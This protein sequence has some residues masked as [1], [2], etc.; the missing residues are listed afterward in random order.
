MAVVLADD[1]LTVQLPESGVVVG[2]GRDEVSRVGAEGAVPDPPLVTRQ[3]GLEGEGLGLLVMGR[4]EI[5]HLPDARGVVGAAG[6]ELLHVWRQEDTS[7]ILL[8]RVE[9][10]HGQELRAV[11]S[12]EE[13]PDKDV[14]LVYCQ[15]PGTS[16]HHYEV[17]LTPLLAAQRREPSLATVTLETETSSSGMSW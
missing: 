5:L 8:V 1:L 13:L 3:G 16:H 4:L 14:S 15:L 10:R 2:A 7:N 11:V 17:L 12:L 9:V 6:R